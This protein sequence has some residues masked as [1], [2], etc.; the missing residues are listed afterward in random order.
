[1]GHGLCCEDAENIMQHNEKI[2]SG[3]SVRI[4]AEGKIILFIFRLE[5]SRDDDSCYVC[6]LD[7]WFWSK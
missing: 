3:K 2:T 4:C 5:V 6:S 7:F 1:M